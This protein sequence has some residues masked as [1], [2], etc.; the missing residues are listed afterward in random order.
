MS[1]KMNLFIDKFKLDRFQIYDTDYWHWSLRPEQVTLGAGVLSL[2]RYCKNLKDITKE[3]SE[4]LQKIIKVVENTLKKAFDYDVI[5]Y[6]ALMMVDKHVH[7]HVIPRY[8]RHIEFA[9][10]VWKD[11]GWPGVPNLNFSNKNENLLIE[12]LNKLKSNLVFDSYSSNKKYKIGYTTGVFDLFHIGHLNIIRKAKECC[13][14]LIV[15]VSTDENVMN[16]KNKKPI[17]PYEERA[18]IIESLKFVN[19]VVPQVNMDKLQAWEN[20]KFDVV[21]HGDDW[22]GSSMYNEIEQQFK[23]VGVDMF[24]FPYTK[25]TS[26][27]KLSSV[28]SKL[29]SENNE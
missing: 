15:G 23:E 7:F 6:L 24:F 17:I 26:S 2:K 29:L 19:R 20:L 25:G 12:V 3:E 22:K 9:D 13:D 11:A 16:Y 18:A 21:F 1:E 14:F 4:D 28:L 27:T 10:E 8:E 5:N